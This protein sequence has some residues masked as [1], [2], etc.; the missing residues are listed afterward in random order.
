V[1]D[2]NDVWMSAGSLCRKPA[3]EPTTYIL[4]VGG[5]LHRARS[6][7]DPSWSTL[8][9][10]DGE[11]PDHGSNAATDGRPFSVRGNAADF[12]NLSLQNASQ[13]ALVLLNPAACSPPCR[14]V[15]EKT[16]FP[17]RSLPDLPS[18]DQAR[19]RAS[20]RRREEDLRFAAVLHLKM[21]G[22]RWLPINPC[23]PVYRS[24][25]FLFIGAEEVHNEPF[26]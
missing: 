19:R 17:R 6:G 22:S 26:Q 14:P 11:G 18:H 15:A 9:H 16:V 2:P 12:G 20:I 21:R 24:Q 5:P 4:F 8:P 7:A 13:P 23:R 1:R 25:N 10:R 3:R